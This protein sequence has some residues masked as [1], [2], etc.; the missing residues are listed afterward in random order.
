MSNI[1]V[2]QGLGPQFANSLLAPPT[3]EPSPTIP[4]ERVGETH[5]LEKV[6]SIS[7]SNPLSVTPDSKISV[8]ERLIMLQAQKK[9]VS[10][11]VI[12]N[13]RSKAKE[14]KDE[15]RAKNAAAGM[16]KQEETRAKKEKERA[17]KIARSEAD[18][19]AAER[20]K[21]ANTAK[22]TAVT[23]VIST[24]FSNPSAPPTSESLP[25]VPEE[26]AAETAAVK[27]VNSTSSLNPILDTSD[28]MIPV[29][30][31]YKMIKERK[32]EAAAEG[33][34]ETN[35]KNPTAVAQN[36]RVISPQERA[37][38]AAL[39]TAQVESDRA[40]ADRMLST[41]E[42]AE[43][44]RAAQIAQG[45][46]DKVAAEKTREANAA[47]TTA[48]ENKKATKVGKILK[49]TPEMEEKISANSAIS[50]DYI[51]NLRTTQWISEMEE[52]VVKALAVLEET[53]SISSSSSSDDDFLM[54]TA[55][56]IREIGL[57]VITCSFEAH[58]ELRTYHEHLE[59]SYNLL[60]V[61]KEH[62]RFIR[63]K[64][65]DFHDKI[66]AHINTIGDRGNSFR[67]AI[68]EELFCYF[69]N[70]SKR[71]KRVATS[72]LLT[73]EQAADV[74]VLRIKLDK[75][76][77]DFQI[78]EREQTSQFC[79]DRF[80]EARSLYNNSECTYE[81][82]VEYADT[83]A[84]WFDTE[85]DCDKIRQ[86]IFKT[87][88]C[89]TIL[90]HLKNSVSV[91]MMKRQ[92]LETVQ[93]PTDDVHPDST[94]PVLAQPE[95][96]ESMPLAEEDLDSLGS[97]E[98]F[99]LAEEAIPTINTYISPD[100]ELLVQAIISQ[101]HQKVKRV[102]EQLSP[103]VN[104]MLGGE[105]KHKMWSLIHLA[106]NLG[107]ADVIEELMQLGP[108]IDFQ[109]MDGNTPLMIAALKGNDKAVSVLL[110]YD[111]DITKSND[112]EQTARD[113]VNTGHSKIIKQL[114]DDHVRQKQEDLQ[115]TKQTLIDDVLD[116]D[117]HK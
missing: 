66:V 58:N 87:D 20:I 5:A 105:Y 38:A 106:A 37:A 71:I 116:E 46:A 89:M 57:A 117:Q 43:K 13:E 26:R 94:A 42:R 21:E 47:K 48:T 111:A 24:N 78:R 61:Q 50:S 4:E 70:L 84:N 45:E 107:N 92:G 96:E 15:Q 103:N 101:K 98:D 79:K 73:L 52:K 65:T 72:V 80:N 77:L 75:A 76:I 39:M 90:D 34:T 2:N 55:L 33:I 8:K 31:R 56:S 11:D 112:N 30:E 10:A 29:K 27:K 49:L 53:N 81:D 83:W 74:D 102:A 7:S 100:D 6:K 40:A 69:E 110:K 95:F 51:H 3:S 67:K 97:D 12:R 114:L 99:D 44:M 109:D 35:T 18:K 88:Q 22:T 41:R 28:S 113:I 9:G 19:I 115:R 23:Q 1:S 16:R 36:L 25:T 68:S 60:N 63:K 54:R 62:I 93:I 85:C 91:E 82:I 17:E 86:D 64:N 14:Q 108:F 104:T 32:A 59:Y